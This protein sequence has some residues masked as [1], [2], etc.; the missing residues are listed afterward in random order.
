MSVKITNPSRWLIIAVLSA[1][2]GSMAHWNNFLSPIHEFGHFM[3]YED[4]GLVISTHWDKIVVKE[5][6]PVGL[7]KG[8]SFE[9]TFYS[10]LFMGSL[11][12][13]IPAITGFAAGCL[14]ST[15]FYARVSTDFDEFA[16]LTKGKLEAN[17]IYDWWEKRYFLFIIPCAL[18]F[19]FF[20]K[21][22]L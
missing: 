3:W 17:Y 16:K 4:R 22:H 14:I 1:A 5:S 18:A 9:L 12:G 10:F 11:L 21:K 20:S 6:R 15:Y 19:F 8:F 7:T 2:I 13:N